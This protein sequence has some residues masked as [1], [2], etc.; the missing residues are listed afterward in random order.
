[1]EPHLQL[2]VASYNIRKA[3]GLDRKR[4]PD[5][6]ISV[7]R[8]VDADIIALQEADRRVGARLGDTARDA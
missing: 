6:I 3:I 5:R 7:L 8:E 4:D 1:M 2:K